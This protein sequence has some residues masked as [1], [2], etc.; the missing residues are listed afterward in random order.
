MPMRMPAI[1]LFASFALAGCQSIPGPPETLVFDAAAARFIKSKGAQRIEGQAY[2]VARDGSPRPAAHRTVR[3]IPATSYA[4]ARL[5][6]LY[7]GRRFIPAA[8]MTTVYP[9]PHYASYTRTTKTDGFGRFSFVDVAAGDYF[10][11]TQDFYSARGTFLP[12]GGAMYRRVS[13]GIGGPLAVGVV[14]AGY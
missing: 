4:Q 5:E 12:E 14:V 3:L 8:K 1:V 2:V 7:Q 13:V 6:A 11:T 9:D 10:V